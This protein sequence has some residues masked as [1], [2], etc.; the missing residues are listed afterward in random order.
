MDNFKTPYLSRNFSE[1]WSR[2]HISLS[3]WF[4]DYLYISLGGN[5]VKLPRWSFN[6]MVVFIVSGLW[7]GA[8]W[9]F[10]VWGALHGL[11]LL[12]ERYFRVITGFQPRNE[13]SL[14]NMLLS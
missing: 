7:H 4:R 14:L 13:W 11:M 9:T 5:R 12:G 3:T 6:I 2:W 1:F 8:N 10:V